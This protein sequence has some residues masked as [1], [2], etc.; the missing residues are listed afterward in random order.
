MAVAWVGH[1]GKRSGTNYHISTWPK[2][3]QG[4]VSAHNVR[5]R[6]TFTAHQL[7]LAVEDALRLSNTTVPVRPADKAVERL[8]PRGNRRLV[9]VSLA[10]AF[11]VARIVEVSET[12][13]GF[14][15]SRLRR[16]PS[17]NLG[18]ST[19]DDPSVI[20]PD[21]EALGT[22]IQFMIG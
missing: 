1:G 6:G 10:A 11:R 15:L 8:G 4:Q 13:E 18:F 9:R 12:P 17:A 16:D 19:T 20:A 3:D 21:V 7:G 2:T 22:S 5:L 14:T